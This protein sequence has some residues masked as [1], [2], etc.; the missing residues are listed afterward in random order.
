MKGTRMCRP[1]CSVR[2]KRPR[3]SITYA[4]CWGTTLTVL[5]STMT[6]STTTTIP[7]YKPSMKRPP[8]LGLVMCS[9][10]LDAQSQAIDLLDDRLLACCDCRMVDVARGPG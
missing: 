8:G 10:G 4:V 5:P 3:F 9:T 6:T 1:A 7:T 2:L